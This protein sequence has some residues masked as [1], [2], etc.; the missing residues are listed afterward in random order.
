MVRRSRACLESEKK[1]SISWLDRQ[2][3]GELTVSGE[4]RDGRSLGSSTTSTTDT[5]DIVLRVVRVV[6]VQYMGDVA[7]VLKITQ[8]SKQKQSFQAA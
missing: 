5:V 1:V 7:D 2:S 4:E 8:V 6:I 3:D